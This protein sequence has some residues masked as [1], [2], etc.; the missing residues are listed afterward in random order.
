MNV[1][2][3]THVGYIIPVLKITHNN[4]INFENDTHTTIHTK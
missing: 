2:V 1:I 4:G 3:V